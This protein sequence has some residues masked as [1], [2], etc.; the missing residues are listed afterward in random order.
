MRIKKYSQWIVFG[1]IICMPGL[2]FGQQNQRE[3]AFSYDSAL[4]FEEDQSVYQPVSLDYVNT[5]CDTTDEAGTCCVD[6]LCLPECQCCNFLE[7]FLMSR[8]PIYPSMNSQRIRVGG[9]LDQGFTGNFQKPSNNFNLPVTFNDRSNE[10]QMNQLY[11]FMERE[12]D[13][14]GDELDWGFRADLLYGTDYFFTTA[15][16]LETN[17]D[18]SAHWN[19]SDGPRRSGGNTFAMY[20][21]A[22]PQL[23]AELYI[24]WLSG[25]SVKAGHFYT[26]I[27]YEKVTAPDNFFYSHSYSMQYGEPFT[28]T[29]ILSTFQV[30]DQLQLLAGIARGWD[31]WEDPNDDAELL[32]GIGWVSSDQATNVNLALSSGDQDTNVDASANR[33]IISFVLS[34]QFNDCLTYV[35]QSDFGI[36]DN[37]AINN[38]FQVV[39]AKW[40]SINQYLYYDV[41]DTL[42]WGARFEWFRDQDFSRVVQLSPP[43]ASGGNYFELTVGANWK[44]HPCVTVRPELRFDWSDTSSPLLNVQG[45]Y[46][47]FQADYQVLLGGDVIIRF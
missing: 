1:V 34:H 27:G 21:V 28:H 14:G 2:V 7:Q 16:G 10:Y 20:G 19:S 29:G 38:Q 23:Y 46:R 43:F 15:I 32:A 41:S 47:N 42:A 3:N 31:A 24:P 9:W 6:E 37:G 26:P 39:P 25:V 5:S 11:L 44:P 35:F 13:F 30:S 18:G 4:E 40:Y 22:L 8:S 36:Q 45:P 33:T 12:V 17:T